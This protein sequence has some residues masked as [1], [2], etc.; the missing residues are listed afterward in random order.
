MTA[1]SIRYRH[2][3]G[4]SVPLSHPNFPDLQAASTLLALL[5]V[6]PEA[7]PGERATW[8][9]AAMGYLASVAR[10]TEG[11]EVLP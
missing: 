9:R 11:K 8:A 10:S 5:I 4:P 6:H 3:P 1:P 2:V 7:V